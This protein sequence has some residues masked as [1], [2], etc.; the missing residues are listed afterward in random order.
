M[1]PPLLSLR[2][3]TVQ[4]GG[5]TPFAGLSLAIAKGDRICLVGRNGCGKSTLLKSLAGLIELDAGERFLQP[6]T[7]VAY[8]PQDPDLNSADS[9]LAGQLTFRL[10][11]HTPGPA[12]AAAARAFRRQP[13]PTGRMPRR[14]GRR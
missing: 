5:Q 10:L 8:L 12:A 4:V 1:S 2:D 7:S 11:D 14:R 6:R 9:A 13:R 3:A